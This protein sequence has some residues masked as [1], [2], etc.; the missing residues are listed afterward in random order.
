MSG[1]APPHIAGKYERRGNHRLEVSWVTARATSIQ[2]L[3]SVLSRLQEEVVNKLLVEG[4][5]VDM[6]QAIGAFISRE[7][8]PLMS[9]E[10]TSVMRRSREYG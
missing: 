4:Y 6:A 5:E 1:Q 7:I 2:D 8:I 9:R 10:L 3:G